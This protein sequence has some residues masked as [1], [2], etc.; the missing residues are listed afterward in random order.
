MRKPRVLGSAGRVQQGDVP[1]AAPPQRDGLVLMEQNITERWIPAYDSASPTIVAV[2]LE[3]M[4]C[5]S[6]I[7]C[8]NEKKSQ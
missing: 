7:T 4:P 6:L 1:A 5:Q 8:A 3:A 2:L